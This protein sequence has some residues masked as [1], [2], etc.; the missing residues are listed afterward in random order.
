[1][2]KH[3]ASV[4]KALEF[5]RKFP[6]RLF[7]K[8]PIKAPRIPLLLSMAAPR[9][10]TQKI[11]MIMNNCRDFHGK[12][13]DAS[14]ILA[15]FPKLTTRCCNLLPIC[16]FKPFTFFHQRR[17]KQ[18]QTT[19]NLLQEHYPFKQPLYRRYSCRVYCF[20]FHEIS[21]RLTGQQKNS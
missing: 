3:L 10:P 11:C 19:L 1:M 18:Q 9:L 15:H 17:K 6:L 21:T 2:A 16:I 7:I 4:R 14:V 13:I 5:I 20:I 12:N 8:F